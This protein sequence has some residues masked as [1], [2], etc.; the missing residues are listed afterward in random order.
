MAREERCE[1]ETPEI[2]VIIP[3][4][5][6]SRDL[7]RCLASVVAQT[8]TAFE[9]ILVD[10]RSTDDSAEICLAWCGRDSRFR[11]ITE[12]VPGAANARNA[13]LFLATG[14]YILFVDSDDELHPDMLEKLYR[15]CE[16]HAADV[17][18]CSFDEHY[19]EKNVPN[20]IYLKNGRYSDREQL[21]LQILRDPFCFYFSVPWNKLIRRS[22]LTENR[23]QFDSEVG[24][25]DFPFALKVYEAAGCIVASEK[26]LY[27]YNRRNEQSLTVRPRTFEQSF[28]NRL[29]AYQSFRT[30]I[31][32]IGLYPAYHNQAEDYILRYVMMQRY[33]AVGN[34]RQK[35]LAKEI[36][37]RKEIREILGN[38]DTWYRLRR[39]AYYIVKFGFEFVL[40]K[41]RVLKR[42]IKGQ[43]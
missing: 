38:M 26:R 28:I 17:A 43:R 18:I 6:A 11:L 16:K 1:M 22:I 2:S 20:R 35:K 4:F 42:R 7:E 31:E 40:A 3:I 37:N 5:N 8:F 33:K 36:E 39:T 27:S 23:I 14:T 15:A 41:L 34:R 25:E 10:N 32:D 9:V 19:K 24:I 21:L 29:Q 13:G 12:D 30:F